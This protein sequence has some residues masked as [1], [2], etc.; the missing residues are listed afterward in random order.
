M[1]GLM[2]FIIGGLLL[3]QMLSDSEGGGGDYIDPIHRGR[4]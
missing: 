4:P 3:W 2:A 1:S